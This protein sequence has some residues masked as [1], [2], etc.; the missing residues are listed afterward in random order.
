MIM[1][2]PRAPLSAPPLSTDPYWELLMP[3]SHGSRSFYGHL[4]SKWKCNLLTVGTLLWKPRDHMNVLLDAYRQ[5]RRRSIVLEREVKEKVGVLL[6]FNKKPLMSNV[7]LSSLP[8]TSKMSKGKIPNIVW[9]LQWVQLGEV[10][11]FTM[12]KKKN[13]WWDCVWAVRRDA[14]LAGVS[15]REEALLEWTD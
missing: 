9:Q 4:W 15:G 7:F 11:D 10:F 14:Q 8:S 12:C 5:M 1:G 2:P 6:H 3:K 13:V